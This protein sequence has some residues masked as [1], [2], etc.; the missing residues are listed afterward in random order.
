MAQLRIYNDVFPYFKFSSAHCT[1]CS[2][3][4]PTDFSG[5]ILI[6]WLISMHG[7]LLSRL[8][9]VQRLSSASHYR[10]HIG[11]PLEVLRRLL[12]QPATVA[13]RP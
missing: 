7:V 12:A 3:V 11:R 9:A 4:P 6:G 1:G 10:S 5:S 8:L 2:C 13:T